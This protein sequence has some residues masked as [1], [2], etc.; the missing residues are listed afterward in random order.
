MEG[1][2]AEVEVEAENAQEVETET[3]NVELLNN[4]EIVIGLDS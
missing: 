4:V 3:E 1:D 2:E